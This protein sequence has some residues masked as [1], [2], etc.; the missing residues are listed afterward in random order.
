MQIGVTGPRKLTAVQ[1]EKA[2]IELMQ[3]LTPS[4]ILHAGD[5]TGLDA[6]ARELAVNYAVC[7]YDAEGWKPWQLQKRSRAMVDTLVVAGGMLHAWPNKACPVGLT[8]ESW[9]GSGTWGTV[10][11]A[12]AKGI[13]VTLHPLTP[14]AIAPAWLELKPQQLVLW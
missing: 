4:T 5:A 12:I 14:E 6:L 10:R 9:K 13:D 3:L 2:A 1:Q 7:R 11:Y 8:V